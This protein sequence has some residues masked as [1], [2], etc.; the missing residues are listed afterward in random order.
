M[1][2]TLEQAGCSVNQRGETCP[3][4]R[5]RPRPRI[6]KATIGRQEVGIPGILHGLIIREF[7]SDTTSL[8]WPG[9]KL[10]DNRRGVDGT[11]TRTTHLCT[12]SAS[13]NAPHRCST[14]A[15]RVAQDSA[16]QCLQNNLSSQRHV[17]HDAVLATEHFYTISLSHQ[18]H[19]LSDHLLPHCP[20]LARPMWTVKKPREIHG[21]VADTV[22]LHFM[23]TERIYRAFFVPGH[24]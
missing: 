14:H 8:V 13:Q 20:V 15:T 10:H 1:R 24:G 22:N 5:Q 17:S 23:D 11:P 16:L 9:D 6:G 2:S 3:L 19:L 7:F 12:Y 18:H 21:G 4:R